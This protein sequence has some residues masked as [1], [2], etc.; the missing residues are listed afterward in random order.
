MS[1]KTQKKASKL[2][3]CRARIARLE[4]LLGKR[5]PLQDEVRMALAKE[6]DLLRRL[7]RV[8]DGYKKATGGPQRPDDRYLSCLPEQPGAATT[9]GQSGA[10]YDGIDED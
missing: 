3:R 4:G 1:S 7:E 6:F 5:L 2:E 10:Q 9:G 8:T